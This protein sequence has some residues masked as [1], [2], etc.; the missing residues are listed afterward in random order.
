M[1]ELWKEFLS[2][3][4]GERRSIITLCILLMLS[5]IFFVLIPYLFPPQPIPFTITELSLSANDTNALK[6]IAT[7]E[8]N[9]W[10]PASNNKTEKGKN[11]INKSVTNFDPNRVT[12]KELIAFGL[13]A[14]LAKTW[15]HYTSKGGRFRKVEDVQKL[16]GMTDD[17]Y[18]HLLP[19]MRVDEQP[20][21]HGNFE[22]QP[23]IFANKV[24]APKA[25][26]LDL[27]TADTSDLKRLPMI[28]SGR[29]KS[30]VKYR[31]MLG[32]YISVYQLKEVYGLNDTIFD[33]IKNM[34]FVSE[35]FT[36]TK[37]AINF[38]DPKELSKHPY[39]RSFATI[40]YNYRKEHG[41][42]SKPAD[43][44]KMA[45]IDEQTIKKILPYINFDAD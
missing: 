4:K 42:F 12:E 14:K 45:G 28:G 18:Q 20:I 11:I 31:L 16:Y 6:P 37:L 40:L 17:L 30:I 13:S 9:N 8:A 5:T 29:A 43:L 25:L 26:S 2:Y 39:F 21:T 23:N 38:L 32:G 33:A 36:P 34:V 10:S 1:F 44:H 41:A 24:V 3:N 22:Q 27:N 7:Y 35:R 15:T 19:Y